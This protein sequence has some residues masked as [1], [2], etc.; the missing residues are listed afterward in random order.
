MR[1]FLVSLAVLALLAPRVALGGRLDPNDGT[2]S[3][4]DGRGTFTIQARGGIVG[5]FA[6]GKVVITDPIESD[7]TGPIVSMSSDDIRRDRSDTTTVYIGT[8]IRFRLIGGTFRIRVQGTGVN[9]SLVGHGNI[10]L[11]GQG[12]DNDGAYSV[13]GN[14]YVP[15]PDL[16]LFLL[17]GSTP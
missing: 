6:R 8:K 1:R 9:L 12:T 16:L 11:N 3:I 5:S 2:L 14:S 13:N 7:G 10:T 15:V 4:R 17:N